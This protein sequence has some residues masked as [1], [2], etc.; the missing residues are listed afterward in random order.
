MHGFGTIRLERHPARGRDASLAPLQFGFGDLAR[1]HAFDL[2]FD[3]IENFSLFARL[4]ARI[5]IE[6][7]RLEADD[8]R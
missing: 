5:E 4:R 3:L 2:Q 8:P 1:G 7:T 6:H